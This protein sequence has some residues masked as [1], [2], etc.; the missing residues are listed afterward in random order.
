VASDPAVLGQLAL[1][2]NRRTHTKGENG[3]NV[4][5]T[6]NRLVF[7]LTLYHCNVGLYSI[8]LLTALILPFRRSL[9]IVAIF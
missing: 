3:C 8:A 2:S 9:K 7:E 1:C 6:V 5:P 4:S